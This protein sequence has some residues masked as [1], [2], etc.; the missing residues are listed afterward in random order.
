M[1]TDFRDDILRDQ[2]RVLAAEMLRDPILTISYRDALLAAV[3]DSDFEGKLV[4]WFRTTDRATD[5]AHLSAAFREGPQTNLAFWDGAYLLQ[6][7]G[8]IFELELGEIGVL[9]NGIGVGDATFSDGVLR[10]DA[11][12]LSPWNA[13]LR[14]VAS[15]QVG[16]VPWDAGTVIQKS[17]SGR[18]WSPKT[19][20]VGAAVVNAKGWTRQIAI[21]GNSAPPHAA[22]LRSSALLGDSA[23]DWSKFLTA[24]AGTYY[25]RPADG[26]GA[27]LEFTVSA[28]DKGIELSYSAP[29]SKPT[30]TPTTRQTP[31]VDQLWY[32][33]NQFQ[34]DLTFVS[35]GDNLKTFAGKIYPI[36]STAP[37]SANAFGAMAKPPAKWG[38]DLITATWIASLG[39]FLAIIGPILTYLFT[40][41]DTNSIKEAIEKLD[42]AV[43]LSVQPPLQLFSNHQKDYESGERNLSEAFN[44]SLARESNTFELWKRNTQILD[45]GLDTLAERMR[46]SERRLAEAERSGSSDVESLR[47]EVESQKAEKASTEIEIKRSTE[48]GNEAKEKGKV[49]EKKRKKKV[50]GEG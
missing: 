44:D 41:R 16:D 3:E 18:L 9:L 37:V 38:V 22:T 20:G 5:H 32:Q 23:I 24:W 49:I 46:D 26:S 45:G 21:T 10:F 12:E 47:T 1:T 29:G 4:D 2:A 48:R 8:T 40:Y 30:T 6:F 43:T 36:G 11:S 34:F 19:A 25:V 33:D 14:F 31:P 50:S 28:K 35:F 27:S 42:K 39:T 17:C 7:D 15:P 13:E